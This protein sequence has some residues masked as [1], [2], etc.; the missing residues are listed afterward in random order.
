MLRV[1]AVLGLSLPVLAF[2]GFGSSAAGVPA[3]AADSI[4][5]PDAPE[6]PVGR[7]S[8]DAP[9][10]ENEQGSEEDEQSGREGG[11]LLPPP[12]GQSI[13]T[14]VRRWALAADAARPR[15]LIPI[16]QL[17]NRGPPGAHR[18]IPA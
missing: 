9:L 7:R 18:S 4:A 17:H 1:W 6:A 16:G 12:G 14:Q 8:G 3:A 5:L 11:H 15:G 2:G 13:A 10:A